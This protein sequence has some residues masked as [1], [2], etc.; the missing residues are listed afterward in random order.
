[1]VLNLQQLQNFHFLDMMSIFHKV[2]KG[3][4]V[5]Y[6]NYGPFEPD[7]RMICFNEE[8]VVKVWSN[9]KYSKPKP[10]VTYRMLNE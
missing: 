4:K 1:M 5:L 10:K 8:A 6:E 2:F 9:V 3:F 7:P